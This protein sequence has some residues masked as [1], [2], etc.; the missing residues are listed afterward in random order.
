[1]LQ[2][3]SHY[4]KTNSSGAALVDYLILDTDGLSWELKPTY[5]Y[6][7]TDQVFSLY[8][9]RKGFQI[10]SYSIIPRIDMEMGMVRFL[11]REIH[12]PR[13]YGPRRDSS[14][15]FNPKVICSGGEDNIEIVC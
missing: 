2:G 14:C 10:S 4:I 11:G 15:W 9:D 7:E 8:N 5:R 6:G 3:F 13:G 12:F 1:M